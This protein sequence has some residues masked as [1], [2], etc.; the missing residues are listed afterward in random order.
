MLEE[1]K[2]T[3]AGA[4]HGLPHMSPLNFGPHA[5]PGAAITMLIAS[6]KAAVPIEAELARRGIT[7]TRTSE[8]FAG[9]CPRCGGVD[10]FSVNTRKQ[11]FN[12]RGC[13]GKGDVIDLVR[14]LDNTNL[15]EAVKTLTSDRPAQ[16]RPPSATAP[17]VKAANDDYEQEKLEIAR[18]IW[19][20]AIPIKGTP[21]ETYFQQERGITLSDVPNY[22]GLRWHPRCPW[23]NG[24][25]PCVV[26]RF[27]D[28]IT[29]EPRGIWRRPPTKDIKPMSLGPMR[30]C[31]IRL[32]PDEDV[33]SGLVIGE[34][35][36]TT[37]S[38]ATRIAH[39]GALL[40]PAWA[41]TSA[42]NL[43]NFPVLPG[44]DALMVLADN[45]ASGRGLQAAMRCATR[46]AE[47]GR[48]VDWRM[49]HEIGSDFN[50]LVNNVL[51]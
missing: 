13:G 38:A 37:L 43:Q 11:V 10:R 9:P 18:R 12:C 23:E 40:Q 17:A 49:T 34:G 16:P 30:G 32:W 26:A 41:A 36:E 29:G 19:Q 47:A 14:L 1:V 35:V 33:T 28:A 51:H 50:D 15:R 3:S 2:A 22:G 39:R 20:E 6:A 4:D 7:L 44:I 5:K 8:G 24:T 21:G 27:T 31:V 25:T 42:G 46:W 48:E 45:D